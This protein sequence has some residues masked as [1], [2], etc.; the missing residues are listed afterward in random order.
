[1]PDATISESLNGRRRTYNP[2]KRAIDNGGAD[3]SATGDASALLGADGLELAC[4][5]TDGRAR[6]AEHAYAL[7]PTADAASACETV[8]AT[9]A[10]HH[11]LREVGSAVETVDCGSVNPEVVRTGHENETVLSGSS[12]GAGEPVDW[13]D[14]NRGPSRRRGR[15]GSRP[16]SDGAMA[17]R[18]ASSSV[19]T[20]PEAARGPNST[21]S[22]GA[23]PMGLGSA[24]YTTSLGRVPSAR[25]ASTGFRSIGRSAEDIA[26]VAQEARRQAR[27]NRGR[28]FRAAAVGQSEPYRALGRGP[29]TP[30]V[31][32]RD[33]NGR[34]RSGNGGSRQPTRPSAPRGDRP[35]AG[36]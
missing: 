35:P 25:D 33:G 26:R 2:R 9:S 22:F 19:L 4:E 6:P 29:S 1:M 28:M 3:A 23:R 34:D 14:S 8:S 13:R 5:D 32:S 21:A 15:G 18:R 36:R 31:P 10:G 11:G 30:S 20:R 27:L 24:P 12:A 17:P 16:A 7:H